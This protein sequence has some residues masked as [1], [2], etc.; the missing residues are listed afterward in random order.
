MFALLGM[1]N[2]TLSDQSPIEE[3]RLTADDAVAGAEFGRSVAIG[4]DLVAVGAGGANAG[5]VNNAGAVY[6]FK[7]QGQMYFPEAK[8]VA[9]DASEGAEF[10]RAVAIQGN[11]VIVGARFAQVEI[12]PGKILLKAGAAYV[13]RKYKGSWHVEDK[14]TSPTPADEDNFGRA[15]AIQGNVLVVTARKENLGAN[16]V[17]AAYV[18]L[19]RGGIWINQEKLTAS[20]PAPRAYF[21]QSVAIQG[22]VIAIG[23]RNADPNEAGAVYLFRRSGDSWLEVA[24]VTP[25]DGVYDDNFAFSVAMVGDAIAVGARRAN[26][27]GAEDA[28]AAY[29]YALD[30]DSVDLITKLTASD[31]KKGDQFGQSIA[32][33]GD[34]VAV[35]ASRA[36]IGPNTKQG[37]VY[38]FHRMGNQWIE[39]EKLT[40]S[41]GITGDEFGYSLSAFGNDM[42]TGAHF[43]DSNEGAAYVMPL[44]P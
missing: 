31:P 26:L 5:S 41:D 38:L 22:G 17:G 27:S 32:M 11:L 2:V 7:R 37:A 35:G 29:V 25:P 9:P 14:L 28:G 43:A 33:A 18:F 24:K 21:G 4:G 19:N 10:G 20:D 40:A 8:L 44:K 23:A 6:L 13:F 36:K 30:L 1:S 3:A 15:L 39:A 12:E 42:V 34:V 16:D